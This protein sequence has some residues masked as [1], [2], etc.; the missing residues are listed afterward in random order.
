MKINDVVFVGF[1]KSELAEIRE[2]TGKD[3]HEELYLGFG[4]EI[5]D[6]VGR[7]VTTVISPRGRI[8]IISIGEEVE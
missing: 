4:Q 7:D 2:K 5:A 8:C 3:G 6:I 1:A